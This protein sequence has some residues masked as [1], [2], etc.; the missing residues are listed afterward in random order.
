MLFKSK[1]IKAV[2][3][4]IFQE[5]IMASVKISNYT[6]IDPQPRLVRILVPP[7]SVIELVAH[8]CIAWKL[9]HSNFCELHISG[10]A[11]WI[12]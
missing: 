7:F 11:F 1:V 4:W 2:A 9:H 10:L 6:C 8:D 12:K 3:L 5:D